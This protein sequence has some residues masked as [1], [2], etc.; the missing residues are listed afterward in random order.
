MP[1][2]PADDKEIDAISDSPAVQSVLSVLHS[3]YSYSPDALFYASRILALC[4]SGLIE[5]PDL[6]HR[7]LIRGLAALPASQGIGLK[8]VRSAISEARLSD[9]ERAFLLGAL[10]M[11]R[12]LFFSILSYR[13]GDE[14]EAELDV[15]TVLIGNLAR[16]ARSRLEA[17]EGAILNFNS[18]YAAYD[19]WCV[20]N[21]FR[22]LPRA[23]FRPA[24]TA[25]CDQVGFRYE[26]EEGKDVCFDL[27]LTS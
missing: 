17:R 21:D 23:A 14:L 13:E 19:E 24:W 11:Y 18:L 8:D 27:R 12:L 25:L 6:D 1:T 5:G 9:S 7:A 20:L 16:F 15:K 2:A 22:P 4:A 26:I 3:K 10:S